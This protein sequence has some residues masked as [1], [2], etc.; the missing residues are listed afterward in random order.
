M[1]VSTTTYPSMLARR[2]LEFLDLSLLASIHI[3][4][5]TGQ[6]LLETPMNI[7]HFLKGRAWSYFR[8]VPFYYDQCEL[9]HNAT[10]C[11][12]ARVRCLLTPNDGNL[13]SLAVSS[14]SNAL[15]HLQRALNSAKQNPTAQILCA[16]QIL[17]LYEVSLCYVSK[18]AP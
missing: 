13:E 10:D 7:S 8:F 18:T 6:K 2:N 15:S 17:G 1:H 3:G 5:N 4:R 12:V 16:T 14:Y 9:I 11:I